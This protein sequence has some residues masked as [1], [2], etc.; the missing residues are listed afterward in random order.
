MYKTFKKSFIKKVSWQGC[1]VV[2]KNI[3]EQRGYEKTD[4]GLVV[5]DR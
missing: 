3:S 1:E 4:T 2:E 5:C